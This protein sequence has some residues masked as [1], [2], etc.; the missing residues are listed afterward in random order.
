[1]HC[2]IICNIE[3]DKMNAPNQGMYKLSQIV[4]MH[5]EKNEYKQD[6]NVSVIDKEDRYLRYTESL[7]EHELKVTV[8]ISDCNIKLQRRGIINMNFHF[9]KGMRTSTF[10]DS[11]AGRHQFEILTHELDASDTGLYIEY[12]LFESGSLLGHYKYKL[13]RA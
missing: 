2:A 13:E 10:Y 5:G 3:G 6:L 1:M 12:D 7:D 9:E 8:R 11:P 4:D